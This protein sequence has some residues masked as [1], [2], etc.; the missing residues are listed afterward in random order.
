VEL[1][2]KELLPANYETS[3]KLSASYFTALSFKNLSAGDTV[4]TAYQMGVGTSVF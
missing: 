4:T 2:N 1:G 3:A